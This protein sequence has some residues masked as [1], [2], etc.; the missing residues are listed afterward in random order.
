MESNRAWRIARIIAAVLLGVVALIL[1]IQN[2]DVVT[3]HLLFW[4]LSTSLVVLI[5]LVL[6]IGFVLG[7]LVAT[8]SARKRSR[9][10]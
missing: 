2:R 1:V 7:L 10:S 3:L 4:G 5:L 8:L 6:L 9:E